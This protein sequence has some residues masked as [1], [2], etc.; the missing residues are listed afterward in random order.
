MH[1]LEDEPRSSAGV[2]LKRVY[3]EPS[4]TD[5]L[6]VLVDRLW[7]RG[8]KK[9]RAAVDEWLKDLAPSPPLRKWF[10]HDPRRFTEFRKR[11]QAELASRSA[12]IDRIVTLSRKQRVTL[13][14]GA[15]DPEINHA[16][17]LRDAIR[18]RGGKSWGSAE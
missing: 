4:S 10:A 15:R 5:G 1:E 16:V 12:E 6:R 3:E 11:Y 2:Q 18:A 17:V 9:E 7:P 8:L 14:Y 13:L